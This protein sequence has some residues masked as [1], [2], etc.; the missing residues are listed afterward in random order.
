MQRRHYITPS[1]WQQMLLCRQG[2]LEI[3]CLLKFQGKAVYVDKVEK[4]ATLAL[5]MNTHLAL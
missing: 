4:L 1:I 5:S 3:P 2:G